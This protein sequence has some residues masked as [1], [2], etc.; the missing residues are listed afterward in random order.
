IRLL[1]VYVLMSYI[2]PPT[3]MEG[4]RKLSGSCDDSERIQ[5]CSKGAR[6]VGLRFAESARHQP[7]AV[8]ALFGWPPSRG[9]ARCEP[10]AAIASTFQC[11]QEAT[12]GT[13]RRDQSHRIGQGAP[14]QW[15][16]GHH[17][18]GAR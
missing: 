14:F 16:E 12:A 4:G 11:T 10:S 1:D 5:R 15:Q 17:G 13:E 2:S 9:T 6:V 7:K 18:R 3:L 8:S